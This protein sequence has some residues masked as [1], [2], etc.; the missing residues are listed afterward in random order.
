MR[1][2]G[3]LVAAPPA[4]RDGLDLGAVLTALI[5]CVVVHHRRPL[6]VDP[7]PGQHYRQ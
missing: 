6:S 5:G 7:Q 2:C 4:R 3:D 1:C